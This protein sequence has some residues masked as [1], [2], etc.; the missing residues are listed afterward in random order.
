MNPGDGRMGLP[1]SLEWSSREQGPTSGEDLSEQGWPVGPVLGK[2]RLELGPGQPDTCSP[3]PPA[4]GR[5]SRY[6]VLLDSISPLLL[7]LS[8]SPTTKFPDG[9]SQSIG[10]QTLGTGKKRGR[11]PGVKLSPPPLARGLGL[12]RS[13]VRP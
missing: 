10:L 12:C 9:L 13:S 7:S 11:A 1:S 4:R 8:F 5:S 6:K 2:E 3:H